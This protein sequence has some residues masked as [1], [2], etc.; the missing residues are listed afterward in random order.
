MIAGEAGLIVECASASALAGVAAT[1]APSFSVTVHEFIHEID[2]AEWNE[3]VAEG[4][5]WQSHAALALL[6][7]G[8]LEHCRARYLIFR[9]RDGRIAAHIAA[10]IIETDLLIFSQGVVKR[11]LDTIRRVLPKFLLPSILECGCPVSA[12]NPICCRDGVAHADILAPLSDAL[13]RIAAQEGIPFVLLRDFTEEEVPEFERLVEHGFSRIANL[14]T[15]QLPLRWR[16]FEEYFL[17]MRSRHRQKIRRG[18]RLA[19]RSGLAARWTDEFAHM[20]EQLGRQWRNV[21]AH[22]KEYSREQVAAEFFRNVNQAFAGRCRVLQILDAER[23]VAHALVGRDGPL[24]R[25]ILFGRED[26]EARDGAYFL[27]I[28][29]II[30]FAIEQGL[31]RIEMR[32]TTYSPKTDFGAQMVPLWMFARVRGVLPR[33][34]VPMLFRLLNPVPDVRDRACFR[35]PEDA[36]LPEPA[37]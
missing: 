3:I 27:V 11:T 4:R 12:G 10:Y 7:D 5:V 34:L 29:R 8:G 22:A 21:N 13:E 14:P 36:V 33:T 26:G 19:E 37:N 32:L 28:A 25:W 16:S 9:T 31:E 1:P 20:A 30:E 23:M 2:P 18:L 24:L 17:A 35:S 15:T 6:E